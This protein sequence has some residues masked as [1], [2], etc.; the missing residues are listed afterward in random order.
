MSNFDN[1]GAWR[2]EDGIWRHKGN[3][4]LTYG[5]TPNGIFTFSIYML[6]SGSIIRGGK[7]RWVL[8]YVDSRNYSLF[9]LDEENFWAKVVVNGKDSER[10]K[11]LH[12]L[13]KDM[14]VWNIQIDASPAGIVH[15]IQG[16][17]DKWVA[18]DSWTESGRDFTKG[19]FGI[20]VNG[21]DEEGLSNFDFTGR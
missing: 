2:Q 21:N 4:T 16:D 8:N 17:D 7:V 18:L 14:R 1:P 10:K 11:V 5:L 20:Q 12:K 15:K 6:K 3:A 19:Q 13:A 9:E